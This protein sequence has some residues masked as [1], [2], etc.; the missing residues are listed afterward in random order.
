VLPVCRELGI[1]FV[2]FSPLGRGFLSGRVT[3][4]DALAP[5]DMRRRVPRFQEGHL[6]RNTTLVRQLQAM[7]SRKGCTPPQLALAWLLA[8]GDDVVPIPGTKRRRYL[9][10]NVAAT[11]VVIT[12]DERAALDAAFPPDA[13]SGERYPEDMDRLVDRGQ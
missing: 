6:Q 4:I 8:Q 10:E 3:D 13:A 7:A 1:G 2:P 5:D 11:D 9:E 12:A